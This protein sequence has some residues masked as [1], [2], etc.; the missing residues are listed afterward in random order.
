MRTEWLPFADLQP[1]DR[2]GWPLLLYDLNDPAAR[3]ALGLPQRS[4]R[5]P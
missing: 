1:A 3:G 2:V 4:F 5:E